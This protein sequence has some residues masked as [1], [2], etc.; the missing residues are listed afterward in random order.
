MKVIKNLE[1]ILKRKW[2]ETTAFVVAALILTTSVITVSAVANYKILDG[3]SEKTL[4]TV[5][6]EAEKVLNEAGIE[7]NEGDKYIVDESQPKETKIE[8]QRAFEIEVIIGGESKKFKTIKCP[9]KDFLA[10][11]N[12]ILTEQDVLNCNLDD[13]TYTG[14]QLV[15]DRVEI[16]EVVEQQEVPFTTNTKETDN[17]KKGKT[18]VETQ[19]QNG[20]K[21]VTFSQK[22]LNGQLVESNP[23]SEKVIKE[24]VN[25]VNLVGTHI[26]KTPAK[27]SNE[28]GITT[29]NSNK[30]TNYTK[31]ITGAVTAYCDK[32]RTS[33]GRQAQRGVVAV[34]PKVIPYGTKLYIPGYGK[35]IAGDTGSGKFLIDLWFE[36]D[37]QCRA[38]G[39]KIMTVY[40]IDD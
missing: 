34:N 28:I 24:P 7:L 36:T 17:L 16:K 6:K 38:W 30:P 3:E 31:A 20:I 37:A 10:T 1:Y 8:V 35:A 18:K 22:F 12:I 14:M 39:R 25:Q 2:K 11:N 9:I 27:S 4:V 13:E 33:T 19:G 21:E 26:K 29:N 23:V 32:G 40:I 5:K 15:I